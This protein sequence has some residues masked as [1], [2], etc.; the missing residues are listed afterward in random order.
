MDS[1]DEDGSAASSEGEGTGSNH[2]DAAFMM[3]DCS[4]DACFMNKG[5]MRHV[6][7]HWHDI[8]EAMNEELQYKKEVQ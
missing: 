5:V 7:K 8:Q 4:Q 6:R 1:D 3:E 2:E